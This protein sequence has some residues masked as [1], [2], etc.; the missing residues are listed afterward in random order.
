VKHPEQTAPV[1]PEL[2]GLGLPVAGFCQP[3][4]CLDFLFFITPPLIDP[5]LFLFVEKNLDS[6]K[7][8]C[9]IILPFHPGR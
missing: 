9:I 4:G 3:P 7:N 2:D 8:S 6:Q 5:F 1:L